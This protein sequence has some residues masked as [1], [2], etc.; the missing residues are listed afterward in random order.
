MPVNPSNSRLRK[1]KNLNNYG[2]PYGGFGFGIPTSIG[3][4][5]RMFTL[6]SKKMSSYEDPL[7]NYKWSLLSH[8]LIIMAIILVN[9]YNLLIMVIFLLLLLLILKKIL[10][11]MTLKLV[12]FLFMNLILIQMYII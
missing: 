2:A 4:R 3:N 9:I 10:M 7:E 11:L 5:F 8:F 1:A 6:Y 12:K